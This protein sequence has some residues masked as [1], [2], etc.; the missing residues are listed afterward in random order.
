MYYV[1]FIFGIFLS[2]FKDKSNILLKLLFLL[3]VILAIFRYGVGSDY[4]NY[5]Y[6][7][8]RLQS[9]PFREII[10]GLDDQ[11]LGFRFIGAFFK[12][13]GI[14]YEFYIA[15]F[16]I[17]NLFYVYK[18]CKNY[19]KNPV[20]SL[21]I[22]FAFYYFV[23]TYSGIRQGLVLSVGMYY[24]IKYCIGK[25]NW[26]FMVIVIGLTF[27]HSSAVLLIPLYFISK[28]NLSKNHLFVIFGLS[29]FVSLM[30]L[31]FIFNAMANIPIVNRIIPYLTD[32]Y[33]ILNILDFQSIARIAFVMIVFIYYDAYAKRSPRDKIVLNLYII[34]ISIYF[35]FK[36]SELTA[37]R[38]SIYGKYLDI[39][40]LVNIYYLYK[41]KINKIIYIAMLLCMINLYLFK[42]LSALKAS[43]FVDFQENSYL[44]PYTNIFNKDNIKLKEMPFTIE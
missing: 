8:Q 29:L 37:S 20:M 42:E 21:V 32:S 34:S 12:G 17:I 6:L 19:S 22:Y 24:L 31:G 36:F 26:R 3:L 13:I 25:F 38:L 39:L 16:A 2:S 28:I 5:K 27:I 4:F 18:I 7:F 41:Y 44:V 40:I 9:N 15:V 43:S 33:S 30:P 35:I 1:T 14:S 10:S 23:W 11:E